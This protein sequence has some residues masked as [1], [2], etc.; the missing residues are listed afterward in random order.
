AAV[1]PVPPPPW[2]QQSATGSSAREDSRRTEAGPPATSIDPQP[3][4]PPPLQGVPA[5]SGPRRSAAADAPVEPVDAVPDATPDPTAPTPTLRGGW[6]GDV[7]E[8]SAVSPA[9]FP[10]SAAP[11]PG[12]FVSPP[13]TAGEEPVAPIR[14]R[15]AAVTRLPAPTA[16]PAVDAR[17][18]DVFPELTGEVSA[19]VGSPA[20]GAPMSATSS[21]AAQQRDAE[22]RPPVAAATPPVEDDAASEFEEDLD[23]TVMVRRKRGVWEL[24][25]PSGAPIPLESDVVILGRHPIADPAHP[26]AQ[27][28]TILDPTRTVSKTHARLERRGDVWHIVD[29]H[30]T[31]GVLL[32]SLLGT[33]IE[34]EAGAEIEVADRFMLGDAA[35]R[36][37]R[38]ELE[39]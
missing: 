39:G 23:Q 22:E 36:L 19:V 30:S 5:A 34:L 38:V 9:P 18:Q 16:A 12:T 17:D 4:A 11:S 20:A 10:P 6:E 15:D 33:D 27:L 14:T 13:V 37:Q 8:V 1:A 35:L 28:V 25:P 29:L 21:V 26:R 24:L 32:P 31:N 3:W 7:D 2:G